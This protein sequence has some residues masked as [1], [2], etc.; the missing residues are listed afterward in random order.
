MNKT[1]EARKVDIGPVACYRE[2]Y[3]FLSQDCFTFWALAFCGMFIAGLVPIVLQGPMFCGLAMCFI[4][5]RRMETFD[6]N[7]LFRGFEYFGKSIVG[8]LCSVGVQFLLALPGVFLYIA[9]AVFFVVGSSQGANTGLMLVFA[10]MFYFLAYIYIF[11]ASTFGF[12]LMWFTCCLV[13]DRQMDSLEAFKT[14]FQ[15][16]R[17]NLVQL[18]L[19]AIVGVAINMVGLLLCCFGSLLLFPIIVAAEFIAYEKAFGL[20]G[21]SPHEPVQQNS[22]PTV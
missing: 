12:T 3:E 13:A 10:A 18:I 5:K 8:V 20:S 2:A 19:H 17:M 15:S 16:V 21:R 22:P 6:F 7:L 11:V 9:A 4:A 1:A 14:A